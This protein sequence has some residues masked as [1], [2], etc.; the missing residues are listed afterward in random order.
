MHCAFD[1]FQWEV[2]AARQDDYCEL[3]AGALVVRQ[4]A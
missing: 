1:E 2:Y 3:P 4:Y